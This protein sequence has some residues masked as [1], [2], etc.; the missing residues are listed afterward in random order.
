MEGQETTF[1]RR[2]FLLAD[3]FIVNFLDLII[4]LSFFLKRRI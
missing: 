1:T 4:K 2:N 3:N